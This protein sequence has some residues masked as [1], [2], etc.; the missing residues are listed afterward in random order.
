MPAMEFRILSHAGLWVR[1]GETSIVVDPWLV[2]SCYW[3]SWWNFP[4]AVYDE[5]EMAAVDAVVISH[6]HWDHWHGPSLRKLFAGKPVIISD[7]PALRSAEDLRA[8]GFRDVRRVKHGHGVQLGALRVTLYQFGRWVND[9]AIVLEGDGV[10]LLDA[11]DAKIAGW[12]LRRLLERHG[13]IDFALRSHSSANARMCWRLE[14][15]TARVFDDHEH[16]M[17][18]FVLFMDAVRPRHAVPFA[19]NHCHLHDDVFAFNDRIATPIEL[20]EYVQSLPPRDW[21][22]AVMLPGSHWQGG[23]GRPE[24]FDLAPETPYL[25][26]PAA[27]RR[28]RDEQAPALQRFREQEN[29]VRVGSGL[30]ERFV[31]FARAPGSRPPR[32]LG[33]LKLVLRWPDARRQ[34]HRVDFDHGTVEP[35]PTNTQAEPGLPMLEMPAIVF[36][37]AVLKNMF[38]HAGISKRCVYAACN[39]ADLR[40]LQAIVDHHDRHELG[41]YPVSWRYRRRLVGAFVRRS[42]E[43]VV[44]AQALWLLKVRRLPIWRVEE[45]ILGRSG[46]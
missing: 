28:Y 21:N 30:L 16:Y 12:P 8:N 36:R 13:P 17:R 29:A 26:M 18:S 31:G 3:R 35:C 10:T 11:N 4:R 5:R 14:G 34:A 33:A 42:R 23:A 22:L 25:D 1:C 37:D 6:L 15:D 41:L 9:T 19:S 45:V 44:Y 2:G 27:L 24:R 40:R 39:E 7:E 46:A 43:L 38:G 32:P 20:R